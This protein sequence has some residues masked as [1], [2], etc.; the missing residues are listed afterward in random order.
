MIPVCHCSLTDK[1]MSGM[2]FVVTDK[3]TA[4]VHHCVITYSNLGF[5]LMN[6]NLG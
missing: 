6:I 3:M 1:Y 5:D 2:V 4:I